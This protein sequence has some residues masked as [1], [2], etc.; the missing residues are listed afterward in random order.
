[1]LIFSF[2]LS[3]SDD[4]SMIMIDWKLCEVWLPVSKTE[5][6]A[7]HIELVRKFKSEA[8]QC[9]SKFLLCL[10]MT[11][12]KQQ[13]ISKKLHKTR[14]IEQRRGQKVENIIFNQSQACG[15]SLY[16][17]YCFKRVLFCYSVLVLSFFFAK[18]ERNKPQNIFWT[19]YS[20]GKL[21]V[22]SSPLLIISKCK[23]I[24]TEL[25]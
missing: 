13:Q 22:Y 3:Y 17:Q 19:K 1:M 7:Q 9:C 16:Q 15:L 11:V 4:L 10:M 24:L 20:F 21:S 12:A 2:A 5:S 18:I 23:K 14:G 25:H 6:I 8:K